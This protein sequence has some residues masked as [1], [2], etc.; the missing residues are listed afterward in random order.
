MWTYATLSIGLS[1]GARGDTK[2][3]IRLIEEGL[4][5]V[6]SGT[7][8]G[9]SE[10]LAVPVARAR[11]AVGENW[12]RQFRNTRLVA[13]LEKSLAVKERTF[14]LALDAFAK[15]E[16]APP[17]ELSLQASRLTGDLFVEYGKAILASQ[18]PKGLKRADREGYE[19]GLKIRARSFFERS[20]TGMPARWNVSRRRE[21]PRTW[22]FRSVNDWRPRRRFSRVRWPRKRGR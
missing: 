8:I 2:T 21:V 7:D 14:R 13:P 17:L 12:A 22:R 15:A 4:R 6:D 1:A 16:N 11:I 19:E 18:R 10:E 3:S 5:K 20:W 9:S